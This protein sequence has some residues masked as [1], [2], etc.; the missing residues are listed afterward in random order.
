MEMG[1]LRV[2][3]F[4]KARNRILANILR[5]IFDQLAYYV[6]IFYAFLNMQV[7]YNIRTTTC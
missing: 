4:K 2:F 5:R 7:A 3:F 1:F 6:I